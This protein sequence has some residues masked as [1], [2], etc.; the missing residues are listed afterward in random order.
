MS[1][2]GATPTSTRHQREDTVTVTFDSDQD[3]FEREIH[4]DRDE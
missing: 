2:G 1:D 4:P 3:V